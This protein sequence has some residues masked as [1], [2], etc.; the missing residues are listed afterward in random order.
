LVALVDAGALRVDVT[1]SP[2]L[3]EVHRRGEAGQVHGEV[4]VLT[5]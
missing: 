4:V 2:P 1:A 5:R 3:A